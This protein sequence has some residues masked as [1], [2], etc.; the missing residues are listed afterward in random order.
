MDVESKDVVLGEDNLVQKV[1][2]STVFCGVDRQ[3]LCF[4]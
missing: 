2:L 3:I 1:C 4:G